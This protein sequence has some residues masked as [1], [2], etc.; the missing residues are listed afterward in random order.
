MA[1]PRHQL[2]HEAGSVSADERFQRPE[3]DGGG[4][5]VRDV[6]FASVA[7]E[8]GDCLFMPRGWWHEVDAHGTEADGVSCAVNWYFE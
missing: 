2:E 8:A 3:R 4:D 1:H 5:A 6:P 7:M